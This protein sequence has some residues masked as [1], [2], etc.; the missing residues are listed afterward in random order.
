MQT[1]KFPSIHPYYEA[2]YSDFFFMLSE[3][4]KD[5]MTE[6]YCVARISSVSRQMCEKEI[7]ERKCVK[8]VFR[9]FI[10]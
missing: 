7:K 5:K 10:F 2:H 9:E 1:M 8:R 4:K 3:K 6:F